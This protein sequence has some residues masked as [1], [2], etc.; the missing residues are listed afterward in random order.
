MNYKLNDYH[1]FYLNYGNKNL[2]VKKTKY[3]IQKNR[4]RKIKI[5]WI[6]CDSR[7]VGIVTII[8]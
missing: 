5:Q 4:K 2:I 8:I 6:L 3:K 7:Y 1:Y